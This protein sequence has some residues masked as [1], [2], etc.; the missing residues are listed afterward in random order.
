MRIMIT[1]LNGTVAPVVAGLLKDYGHTVVGWDRSRVPIDNERAIFQFLEDQNPDW[2][3]HIATGSP[4]W[5]ELIAKICALKKIKLLYTSSA[6][7]FSS[8]QK[9]PFRVSTLPEP[10]DDYGRYKYHCEELIKRNQADVIIARLAWQIGDAW[11]WARSASP[12][13]NRLQ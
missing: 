7:V 6:S 5:A 4:D 12:M 10:E 2:F 11:A 8:S 13:P 9:G 3:L 1:G